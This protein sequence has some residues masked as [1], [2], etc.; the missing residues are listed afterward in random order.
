MSML[1]IIMINKTIWFEVGF[2]VWYL[3]RCLYG[4]LTISHGSLI[5]NTVAH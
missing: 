1:R 5:P 2:S 4:M 3:Y